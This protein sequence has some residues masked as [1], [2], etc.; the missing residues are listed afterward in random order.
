MISNIL[1]LKNIGK[2]IDP[3]KIA[4]R[5]FENVT[6]I[7]G[8]NTYGKTTF[9]SI[10][11][12]LQFNNPLIL[13]EKKTIRDGSGK[14]VVKI[15]DADGQIYEFKDSAW[16]SN[17]SRLKIQVFD[18]VFV[19]ENIYSGERITDDHHQCLNNL[20]LGQI[21]VGKQKRIDELTLEIN[22]LA[23]E[24]ARL[25]REFVNANTGFSFDELKN[26]GVRTVDLEN[27]IE[28]LESLIN[29]VKN[30]EIISGEFQK[31]LDRMSIDFEK[32][33]TILSKKLSVDIGYIKNHLNHSASSSG[34]LEF[35]K[36]G[37][38]YQK[39][40][41]IGEI[42]IFCGQE[43]SAKS[44][45]HLKTFQEFFTSR[46]QLVSSEMQSVA[47]SLLQINLESG[48]QALQNVYKEFRIEGAIKSQDI[49]QAVE[50]FE[51]LKVDVAGKCK[52]LEADFNFS[53]LDGLKEKINSVIESIAKTTDTL[54]SQSDM[55][56]LKAELGELRLEKLQKGQYAGLLAQY[57]D[58]EN[59]TQIHHAERTGIIQELEEEMSANISNILEALN[60]NLMDLHAGFQ[61]SRLEHRKKIRSADKSL[62]SIE[63]NGK[64]IPLNQTKGAPCFSSVLSD[65]DKKVL[66][67]SFFLSTLATEKD[68]VVVFDD[69]VNSFDNERKRAITLKLGQVAASG[70]QVIVLTHDVGFLREINWE[71]SLK[72]KFIVITND[73]TTSSLDDSED[74]RDYL[75][76][77]HKQRM[78]LL[79]EMQSSGRFDRSFEAECRMLV[80]HVFEI[81]HQKLFQ[82]VER[83][84]IRSYAEIV[85]VGNDTIL[86]DFERLGNYLH[87][88]LHDGS[89]PETGSVDNQTTISEFF[90]CLKYI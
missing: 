18:T 14:P 90:K 28:A 51:A 12:S 44:A 59:R 41:S 62:Y 17:V 36:N 31:I 53:A 37:L 55:R 30:V 47:D 58:L 63:F 22:N 34:L 38:V 39:S 87:V 2:F 67:L 13:E 57:S 40:K 19:D 25:A 10:F 88:P 52:N 81:K 78:K 15:R 61:I 65:S 6:V 75:E 68:A 79:L 89:I 70:K 20:I 26:V 7:Y 80:E 82:N 3:S 16:T 76:D 42:C 4:G 46:Y 71:P 77:N 24:K 49:V 83:G 73:G 56:R 86:N 1:D 43:I 84:S 27:K 50:C 33:R 35:M 8:K 66:A 23:A 54:K 74:I 11:R 48:L 21:G 45:E 60:Q 64:D 72:N 85:F 5:N 9:S 32:I 69:P 29:Q